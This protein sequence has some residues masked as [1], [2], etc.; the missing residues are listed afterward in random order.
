MHFRSMIPD[1]RKIVLCVEA[2]QVSLAFP[3]NS[4][5]G[6]VNILHWWVDTDRWKPE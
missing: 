3:E 6:K 5:N 1:I 2:Y 4:I